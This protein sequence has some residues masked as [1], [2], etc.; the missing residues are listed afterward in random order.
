MKKQLLK[1]SLWRGL[2]SLLFLMAMVGNAWGETYTIDFNKG[3]TNGTNISSSIP[4]VAT[5][6]QSGSDNISAVNTSSNCY[7]NA[8]G[9]G[10]RLAKSGGAG[11]FKITL[12]NTIQAA[13]VSK[14]VVYA[15]KVS[16]NTTST[17]K[18]TPTGTV[19]T[20]TDYNNS[21]LSAYST[22]SSASTNYELS[23]IT[24]NGTLSTLQFEA[25]SK[26]YVM[27]HRIDIVTGSADGPFTVTYNANDA[28]SGSVP[29]DNAKHDKNSSVTVLGN[30]GSLARTGYTYAGWNTKADASGTDYAAGATFTITANTTL[31]AKWTANNYNVTFDKNAEDA[32]GSMEPQQITFDQSANLTA[33]AFTR[34]HHTFGGWATT[35][36]GTKSYDDKASYK[37]TSE[38]ATLYAVWTANKTT[39]TL[40][41]DGG[42]GGNSS[43]T[44]TYGQA[45]PS[46]GN[47]PTKTGYTFTGYYTEQNGQGT[48]YYDANN[49]SVK[50]WDKDDATATLY[51]GWEAKTITLTLNKGA[52]GQ[53]DGTATI[54][55]GTSTLLTSTFVEPTTGYTIDGYYTTS[56]G[57]SKV[58]NADGTLGSQLSNWI[59]ANGN[60]IKSAD[61]TLYAHYTAINYNVTWMANGQSWADK[62]GSTTAAYDAKI[63]AVPTTTP[64][65]EFSDKVF[66]GWT[67]EQNYSNESTAPSVLFTKAAD[68]PTITGDVTYYAVFADLVGTTATFDAST[69]TASND[70]TWTSNG[71]TLKLSAGSLYQTGTPNTF[72]VTG[73]TSNYF[74]ITSETYDLTKVVTEVTTT[75]YKINS[76]T[77][78]TLS[79]NGTTQTVASF[80]AGTKSVDCKASSSQIRAKSIYVEAGTF[81]NYATSVAVK[82]LTGIEFGGSPKTVY[83]EEETFDPAGITVLA[84]FQGEQDKENITSKVTLTYSKDPLTTTTK[85]INVSTS[86]KGFEINKDYTI[87]VNAIPTYTITASAATG[88]TYTVKIGDAEAANVPAEG[89]TYQS[90]AEKVITLTSVA[91]EG[92][93]L[94]STPFVVKD[95][96]DKEVKVSKSGDNYTFTM[97]AKAVTITAK[98]V[99]QYTITTG[100]CEKGSISGIK[101]A[102][103]NAIT[104]TS[105]GSKVVVEVTPDEHWYIKKVYYLKEGVE[106]D[107]EITATEGVYSFTMP[108]SNVTV[109]ANFEEDENHTATFIANGNTYATVKYYVD[110]DIVFPAGLQD[111]Y[112]MK[113]VGWVTSAIDNQT[114]DKPTFVTSAK[115]GNED[116]KYH[117]VYANAEDG[118]SSEDITMSS[119]SVTS[120]NITVAAAQGTNS[121]SAPAYT[122][123]E[124]RIYAG[125]TIT[126]STT[127]DDNITAVSL[128]FHKQG[129]KDYFATVSAN[130]GTYTSGGASTSDT[131]DKVDTWEGSAKSITFSTSGTGQRVLVSAKVTT[132]SVSYSGYWS[133]PK[134]TVSVTISDKCFEKTVDEF[135]EEVTYYYAT[136][137]SDKAFDSESANDNENDISVTASE[138]GLNEDGYLNVAEYSGG[139][140]SPAIVPANT[141][142]LLRATAPG[143]YKFTVVTG[144]EA[145]NAKGPLYDEENQKD[146]NLLRPT[147]AGITAAQMEAKDANCK[148]YRLTMHNK[149]A[150]N[151][152]TIGFYWGAENGAAFA[153]GANKAYLAVPKSEGGTDQG[154]GGLV[155]SYWF[156][157]NDDETAI[158][159]IEN[160]KLTIE[161]G[162]YL[163]N[164]K[165]VIVKNGKK[166][167]TNGQRIK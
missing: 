115:M 117:A 63:A 110:Q 167:N 83:T 14:V 114:D 152:G 133:S 74:R 119:T 88:G 40:N 156:G 93:Q 100:T 37:M 43:V 65:V 18:V 52:H 72:T 123:S 46:A 161:N 107:N 162:K 57:G 7:Y 69:A 140:G 11:T 96:E 132:G 160:G 92:Y 153:L 67:T 45:M 2:L 20:A 136:F 95:A 105:E 149:T 38:G 50:N 75:T 82:T 48:K 164:G 71:I 89:T 26:G 101:N 59:D 77:A 54:K 166:Y 16:G 3:T 4:S 99:K 36:S 137:S 163:E 22:S 29:T 49:T 148:Y 120:G 94:H 103:G 62:G 27:L 131:D 122:S 81:S 145:T 141:G 86:Y 6:C 80:T 32:T 128:T 157:S 76:V 66:V 112:G 139:P 23:E 151:P 87:T 79:T 125:N 73:G 135:D 21:A 127:G 44:A 165:I 142:V 9:C 90:R 55:Y 39:V 19:T 111:V 56:T 138:V 147:G 154:E 42:T 58:L 109:K 1:S 98:Y 25:L 35:A 155:K 134:E 17:L 41:K 102:S 53:A 113:F 28:T 68:A 64:T 78:G 129:S 106:G 10:V 51:A 121:S 70:L 30:T 8:S 130:T 143:T 31:Y 150:E 34:A 47:V 118:S 33:N 85:S 108:A 158:S 104:A 144:E 116:L 91:S 15:S 5:L 84:S 60:C 146:N 124:C 61:A 24:I 97:P 13:T 12:S 126:V 159:Q